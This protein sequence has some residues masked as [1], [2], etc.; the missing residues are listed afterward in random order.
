M[1][2]DFLAYTHSDR[3]AQTNAVCVIKKYR[4]ENNMSFVK[5]LTIIIVSFVMAASSGVNTF[6]DNEIRDGESIMDTKIISII[7]G[8]LSDEEISALK[9]TG[10]PELALNEQSGSKTSVLRIYNEVFSPNVGEPLETRLAEDANEKA[11]FTDYVKLNAAPYVIRMM[12][13]DVKTTASIDKERYASVIP[14][15]ISDITAL[16]ESFVTDENCAIEGIYCFDG[17]TSHQGIAVYLKTDKGVF[18]RYYETSTSEAIL[19]TEEEFRLK[20]RAYYDYITSYGYNYNENGE[21][22]GGGSIS[23]LT[24]IQNADN[25]DGAASDADSNK[26]I[27]FII[28]AII[29]VALLIGG[30]V[31]FV[32]KKANHRR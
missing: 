9:T 25:G 11:S 31:F 10:I 23:F 29:S 3:Y 15:Y 2:I 16:S 6:A 20:G 18:V 24:F 17:D 32:K 26:K 5:R 13:D 1:Q 7:N 30:T 22:L 12:H 4:E 21:A 14:T 28:G 19:F 27:Y 8:Q